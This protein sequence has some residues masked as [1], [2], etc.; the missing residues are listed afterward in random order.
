M[1]TRKAY[2]DSMTSTELEQVVHT[3]LFAS[4]KYSPSLE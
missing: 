4:V 2:R 1:P 3:L